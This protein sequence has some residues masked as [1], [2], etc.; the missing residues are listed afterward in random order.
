MIFPYLSNPWRRS[1][2]R[3]MLTM[4]NYADYGK[5]MSDDRVES[6][7]INSTLP[8]GEDLSDMLCRIKK[9]AGQ[10]DVYVD[11]KGRQLRIADYNVRILNDHEVHRI[12]LSHSIEISTPAS[13]WIDDG[14]FKGSIREVVDGKTL[15]LYGC[16]ERGQ[17][18]AVAERGQVG[19]RPS[20]SVNIL[21]PSLKVDGYL[22]DKDK[23]YIKAAADFGIHNILASYFEQRSDLDEIVAEDPDAL[24]T[25]KIESQKG[26]DFVKKE[27]SLLKAQYGKKVCL[28]LARGDMYVEAE[29]PDQI[30]DAAYAVIRAEKDAI[31]A[32]RL[33]ESL[34]DPKSMPKCQDLFDLYC[35]MQ[36]GY[37]RFMLGDSLCFKEECVKSAVGL[38]G[39]MAAKFERYEGK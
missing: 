17:G 25:L 13:L 7:R 15:V 29:M 9:V 37:R 22:T 12:T 35:G 11:V 10:K 4:P 32:S 2:M 30:I 16:V 36:M 26:L 38:F 14:N 24:V 27:Y 6:V 5:I 8:A 19:I 3:L 23:Q 34:S 20:M 31:F 39:V 18:L 1:K 33:M 28:M 21:S